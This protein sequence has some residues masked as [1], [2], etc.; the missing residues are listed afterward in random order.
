M[1]DLAWNSYPSPGNHCGRNEWQQ[2]EANN[3]FF[4]GMQG[5]ETL[6]YLRQCR[7]SGVGGA[8]PRIDIP[9]RLFRPSVGIA[10]CAPEGWAN[11]FSEK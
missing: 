7:F 11:S 10:T 9:A 8:V 4:A 2:L 6:F 3:L 5:E 1:V